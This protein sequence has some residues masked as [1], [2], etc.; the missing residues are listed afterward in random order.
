[1]FV[2]VRIVVFFFVSF[3]RL[4]LL[5]L[6]HNLKCFATRKAKKEERRSMHICF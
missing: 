6:R 5:V 1:M 4:M 3:L 2:R